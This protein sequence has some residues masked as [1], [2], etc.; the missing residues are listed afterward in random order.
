VTY[1]LSVTKTG[2]G[3]VSSAPAGINCGS[4]CS[5]DITSGSA[6]TL[7]AKPDSGYSFSGWSG[8]CSGSGT[9]SV[10]MNKAQ[11]VTATFTAAPVTYKLTVT[12]TG[13][14]TVS[15]E[16]AGIN[17]GSDCAENFASGKTVTLTAAPAADSTFVSWS[18]CTAVAAN[19]LH[20][21]V[22]M[23]KAS[24]VSATFALIPTSGD[25]TIK[26]IGNGNVT[27]DPAAINC[28]TGT[29]CSASFASGTAVIL[30]ATPK[31]G[32]TLLRWGGCTPSSSKPLHCRVTPTGSTAVT[33]TFSTVT[34]PTVDLRVMGITLTPTAPAANSTFTVTITVKNLGNTATDGGYLD[35]WTDKAAAPICKEAGDDW[36]VIDGL[37]AG[38]EKQ[39]TLQLKA[40]TAGKKFL[41]ILVDSRCEIDESNERNNQTGRRYIVK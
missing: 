33:A 17:C 24:T 35:V 5:E 8:A 29:V 14:G 4:D 21:T 25:L 7:T 13:N 34:T 20:C 32:E 31:T 16:P 39:F 23:N 40:T 18:G 36:E 41:R 37:K 28:G 27:S 19:P 1:K 10:S 26:T 3:T 6:V 11:T 22:S 9:C 15:S 38:E 12:K 2:N 30:T